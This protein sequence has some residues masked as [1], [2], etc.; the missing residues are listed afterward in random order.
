MNTKIKHL[1]TTGLCV[2]LLCVL[3]LIS[4]PLGEIPYSLGML[5]VFIIGGMLPPGYATT[6]CFCY[7]LLGGIGMPVFSRFTGGV[8]VLFGPTGGFLFAYPLMAW[9]VSCFHKFTLKNKLM[10]RILGMTVAL[11]VGYAIG[12]IWFMVLTSCSFT[13]AVTV[14]VVPFL[15]FDIVKIAVAIALLQMHPNSFSRIR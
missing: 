5:G 4:V 9:V 14:C 12:T 1:T 10:T 8:S 15:W 11:L 2:A 3:S 7:L 13:A 6:A